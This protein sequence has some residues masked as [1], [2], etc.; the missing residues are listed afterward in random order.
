MSYLQGEGSCWRVEEEEE[1]RRRSSA[2]SQKTPWRF[3][4][5]AFENKHSTE[6]EARL[7]FR[8]QSSYRRAKE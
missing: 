6:I 4:R 5:R 1:T 7:T 2:H 8:V 3:G